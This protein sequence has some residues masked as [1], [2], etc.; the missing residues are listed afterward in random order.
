MDRPAESS[1]HPRRVLGDPAVGVRTAHLLAPRWRAG[2]GGGGVGESCRCASVLSAISASVVDSS[3]Q[4]DPPPPP[5]RASEDRKAGRT[6]KIQPNYPFGSLV[7][8]RR[9][10]VGGK[11]KKTAKIR[12]SGSGGSVVSGQV[13]CP[14]LSLLA[15]LWS[16]RPMQSSGSLYVG[17]P[18]GV[19][20]VW[21]FPPPP[22]VIS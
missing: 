17:R 19:G 15:P 1:F 6:V 16:S 22:E 4:S 5:Q 9:G 10:H 13:R 3:L 2:P 18:H 14:G 21:V 20:E 12:K 11:T 8:A 7:P